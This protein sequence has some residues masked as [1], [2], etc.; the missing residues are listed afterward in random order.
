[1]YQESLVNGRFPQ[2]SIRISM[3]AIPK[4]LGLGNV[5]RKVGYVLTRK[6][7]DPFTLSSCSVKL[8]CEVYLLANLRLP[9]HGTGKPTR[10]KAG[11][12]IQNSNIDTC[13]EWN[14]RI[15]NK[16]Q[17]TP[18]DNI[19]SH[20][21]NQ[22]TNAS[23]QKAVALCS[24]ALSCFQFLNPSGTGVEHLNF[25][26]VSNFAFRDPNFKASQIYSS[27]KR[28]LHSWIP[29]QSQ[30]QALSGTGFKILPYEAG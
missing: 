20:G 26:I 19:V 9:G 6:K 3:W 17:L 25:D 28:D 8:A 30:R 1:M 12:K 14:R 23:N 27:R 18:W 7:C 29:E 13:P 2:M 21:V 4:A 11:R 22:N 24:S 16:F 10:R 15:R 5:A